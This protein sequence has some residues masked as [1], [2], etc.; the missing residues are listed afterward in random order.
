[1]EAAEGVASCGKA[2]LASGPK[3]IAA[4]SKVTGRSTITPL[5]SLRWTHFPASRLREECA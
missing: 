1:M 5:F 2:G 4:Q 3:A